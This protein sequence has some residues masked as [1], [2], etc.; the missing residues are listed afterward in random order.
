MTLLANIY[1]VHKC[2]NDSFY[3]PVIIQIL[4][5]MISDLLFKGNK[6]I[7][8]TGWKRGVSWLGNNMETTWKPHGFRSGNSCEQK[9]IPPMKTF[10]FPIWILRQT[11]WKLEASKVK[12]EGNPKVNTRNA[13]WNL[14]ASNKVICRKPQGNQEFTKKYPQDRKLLR[15]NFRDFLTWKPKENLLTWKHEHFQT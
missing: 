2:H 13:T 11:T 10:G 9:K 6:R 4:H 14:Q 3:L 1:L 7:T 12:H 8:N 5:Q 15:S